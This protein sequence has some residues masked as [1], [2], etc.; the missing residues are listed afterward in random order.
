MSDAARIIIGTGHAGYTLA[1]EF[2]KLDEA[3]PL[4]LISADDGTSYYK[5]N[6]SL[7][8]IHI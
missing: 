8:L 1:R 6:L 2:R 4:L 7:S 3:A 5:P